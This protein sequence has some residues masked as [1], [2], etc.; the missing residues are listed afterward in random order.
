MHDDDLIKPEILD[1]RGI[2]ESNLFNIEQVDL[3]FSNGQQRTFERLKPGKR[4]AVIIAAMQDADTILLVK[5]YAVGTESYE[6]GLPKGLVDAGET[7]VQASNRE[8][9]EE[10]GMKADKIEYVMDVVLA[11]NYMSHSTC[12]MLAYHLTPSKLEGDEP[13]PL[14]VVP[15]N[16]NKMDDLILSG[17]IKEARSIAGL[18]IIKNYLL[19][20]NIKL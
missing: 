15:I 11:P 19:R 6:I 9:Q 5:E 18:Y 20:H 4:Q 12:L 1:V 7:L 2:A 17:K 8:L 10:I 13:E 3:K 16:I 14:Q